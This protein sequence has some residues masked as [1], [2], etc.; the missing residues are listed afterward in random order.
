MFIIYINRY[1][2]YKG[3]YGYIYLVWIDQIRRVIRIY[4]VRFYEDD[5][6]VEDSLK[7]EIYKVTFNEVDEEKKDNI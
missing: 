6:D 1:Y 2:S 4:D 3:I 7:D 5:P